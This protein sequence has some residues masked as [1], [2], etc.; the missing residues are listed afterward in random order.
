MHTHVFQFYFLYNWCLQ[1]TI[2]KCC[3]IIIYN[4]VKC[5]GSNSANLVNY[6]QFAPIF[7][8][9]IAL[10]M[11]ACLPVHL[12]VLLGLLGLSLITHNI[13]MKHIVI[14]SDHIFSSSIAM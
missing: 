9:S 12:L 8:I 14:V 10:P 1:V 6:K 4:T 5:L 13:M 2:P 11:A 3:C 7:T